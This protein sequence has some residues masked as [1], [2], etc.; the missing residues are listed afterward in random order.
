MVIDHSYRL[1]FSGIYGES[2]AGAVTVQS[3]TNGHFQY[4]KNSAFAFIVANVFMV[5]VDRSSGKLN[6]LINSVS[7]SIPM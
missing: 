3:I 6:A 1:G 5:I 2:V 4:V 7:D